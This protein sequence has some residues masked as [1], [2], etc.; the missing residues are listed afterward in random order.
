MHHS[1]CYFLLFFRE[2]NFRSWL[3]GTMWKNMHFCHTWKIFRESNLLLCNLVGKMRW[4]HENFSSGLRELQVTK[5]RASI[6]FTEKCKNILVLPKGKGKNK[7]L[8]RLKEKFLPARRSRKGKNF[9]LQKGKNL[10]FARPL[11]QEDYSY[12]FTITKK[13]TFSRNFA[14]RLRKTIRNLSAITEEVNVWFF[15]TSRGK[16]FVKTLEF[17]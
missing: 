3:R 17:S 4:F 2:I 5:W 7:I 9:Y 10:I 6:N 11:G 1:F 14:G 12:T 15:L 16:N 13:L 8:T